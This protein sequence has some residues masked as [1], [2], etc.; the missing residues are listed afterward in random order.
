[1]SGGRLSMFGERDMSRGWVCL[2]V[3]TKTRAVD[4]WAVPFYWNAFLK[5][6]IH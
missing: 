6:D 4:K 1:M 5:R 2:E 3:A